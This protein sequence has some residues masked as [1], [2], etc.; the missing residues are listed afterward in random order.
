MRTSK[1]FK[2]CKKAKISIALVIERL[3]GKKEF[4]Q[5]VEVCDNSTEVLGAINWHGTREG[6][7]YWGKMLDKMERVLNVRLRV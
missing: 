5:T 7:E 3:G 6:V 1:F 2:D 4:E